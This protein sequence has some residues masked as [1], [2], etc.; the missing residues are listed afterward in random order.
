M[1]K[2]IP[3]LLCGLLLFSSG[4]TSNKTQPTPP[5]QQ[6]TGDTGERDKEKIEKTEDTPK[7]E[8]KVGSDSPVPNLDQWI[9]G[10]KRYEGNFL[11]DFGEYRVLL[12]SLGEKVLEN[13]D[14]KVE[15]VTKTADK[16]VVDVS[17][18]VPKEEVP[19]SEGVDYPYEVVTIINDNKPIEIR[20]SAKDESLGDILKIGKDQELPRSKSFIVFAPIEND[21][22]SNPVKISG[23]ARVFEATFRVHIEDGHNVLAEKIITAD[24]GAP[25][26]GAFNLELPFDKATN[27]SGMM[28]FSVENMENGE[29]IEE[30]N[31]TIKF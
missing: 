12:V 7:N 3:I 1:N 4:C 23:K 19:K 31:I 21:K 20:H 29:L 13:Y 2:L 10:Y 15:K 24:E 17:F 5:D 9:E 25:E 8:Y 6:N 22:I 11:K 27:P 26:W 14:V 18:I 28:I 16:W 30:L